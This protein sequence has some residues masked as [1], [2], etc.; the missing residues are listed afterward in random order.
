MKIDSNLI[1][2][3][4]NELGFGSLHVAELAFFIEDCLDKEYTGSNL[5]SILLDPKTTLGNLI[6]LLEKM[7]QSNSIISNLE[8]ENTGSKI[9][10]EDTYDD[11]YTI[12]EWSENMGSCIDATPLIEDEYVF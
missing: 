11:F 5:I 6:E 8:I 4:L 3:S 7:F 9:L 12:E 1:Q 2:R 10:I